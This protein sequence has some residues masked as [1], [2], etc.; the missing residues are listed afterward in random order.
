M[1]EGREE[2]RAGTNT[3]PLNYES[4]RKENKGRKKAGRKGYNAT[5]LDRWK[6]Q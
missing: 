2:V 3:M 4:G 1:L 5:K 6:R